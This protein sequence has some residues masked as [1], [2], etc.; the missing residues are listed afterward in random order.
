MMAPEILCRMA[1][2]TTCRLIGFAL[3]IVMSFLKVET[4]WSRKDSRLRVKALRHFYACSALFEQT[5]WLLAFFVLKTVTSSQ[6]PRPFAMDKWGHQ[7]EASPFLAPSSTVATAP[8]EYPR[9]PMKMGKL[10]F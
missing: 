10:G 1:A 2:Q 7:I 3:D 9:P 8:L 6:T 5:P 4:T